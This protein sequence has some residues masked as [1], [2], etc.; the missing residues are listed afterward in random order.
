[1]PKHFAR[2]VLL[3]DGWQENVMIESNSSGM[4]TK[5]IQNEEALNCEILDGIV[6]PGM[7]NLH[8]HAFQRAMAGFTEFAANPQDNFWSWRELM[9][10]FALSLS[11]E[12]IGAIA[13][14][15]YLEMLKS[16]YTR[17]GEFHYLHHDINGAAYSDKAATSLSVINAAKSVGIGIT[18][19]PV[20]Y[21]YGGFNNQKPGE[22]QRRFINSVDGFLKILG[23]L[24]KTYQDDSAVNIGMAH[25]SLRA[26]SQDMLAE[27]TAQAIDINPNLPM[28]IHIAEQQ[29]EVD[30]CLE[31]IGKRPVEYL[32]DAADIDENWCLVHATH[33]ND[34]E[35]SMIAQSRAV[36]G[37]CPTT[38]TNLGDGIFP[39][40]EF[41]AA[42]GRFGIGSDSHISVSVPEELRLL[43]YGQRL[44]HQRRNIAH[45]S[46]D[47]NIGAF[48]YKNACKGGAQALGVLAG[49][50]KE[51]ARADYVVLNEDHPLLYGKGRDQILDSYVFAGSEPLV[52]DVIVSGRIIIRNGQ[53]PME[54]SITRAYK[55]TLQ[56]ILSQ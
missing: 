40:P 55:K 53:H 51:N 31:F 11:P 30:D 1:M 26:V 20:L 46:A 29:K 37:L 21:H 15:L 47:K 2:Y 22:G 39:L 25:H 52:K 16:G 34:N 32:Y 36:A 13:A 24:H 8:S 23:D 56:K 50:I 35:I 44:T 18:H 43:E 10:Q 27:A 38:E 12:D 41:I 49:E 4:I 9:Y 45:D 7:P 6:I 14:Q 48:L 33:L 54:D 17:V 28:H 19:L 42:Q 5:I 3:P